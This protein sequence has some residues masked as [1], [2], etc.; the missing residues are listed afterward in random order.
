MWMFRLATR[1][2]LDQW[3]WIDRSLWMLQ[4][5]PGARAW[6]QNQQW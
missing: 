3:K 4:A 5:S 2:G 1:G 6:D